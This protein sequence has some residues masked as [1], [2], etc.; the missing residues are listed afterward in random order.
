MFFISKKR[1]REEVERELAK[2]MEE[3]E[4]RRNLDLNFSRICERIRRLEDRVARLEGKQNCTPCTPD[5]PY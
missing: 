5:L 1:F 3:Q 2:K 4:Y